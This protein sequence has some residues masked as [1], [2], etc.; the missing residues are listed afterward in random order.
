MTSNEPQ[1]TLVDKTADGIT[2]ITINRS[3]RRN[4]IDGPTAKA[5]TDALL[6][7]ENDPSQKVCILYGAHGTFCSGFDLHEVAKY[8]DAKAE[9]KGPIIDPQHHVNGRNIGPIGPSRMQIKKPIISAVSGY[10]VAGGLELSLIGDIR[11][12]EE[13]AIFG[14]FCR[15]FGVP[16]I[17][18]GT[19]RLQAIIGL[20]RAL[21]MILTGRGVAAHEAL[22]MGLANRVVPRG[23]AL[24]EATK[25][26]KQL[27]TFPQS[28]MN[29]DR[30]NCYYSAYN[31]KSFEDALSNEFENGVRIIAK[32]SIT[33]AAEFSRGIGRHGEIVTSRF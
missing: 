12:A 31:A 25:I 10:A 24:A 18:G 27:L 33:G 20:G 11:V 17:D 13:D 5:L 3:H 14:V 32:E 28:C 1:T 15:R 26:A 19:V 23:Q 7:F 22:Q 8:G 30:T 29:A 2:T 4:A 9:Y 6:E 16:L 21:D